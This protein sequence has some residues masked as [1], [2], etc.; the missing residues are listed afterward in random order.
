MFRVTFTS[1]REGYEQKDFA[2][3]LWAKSIAHI[4]AKLINHGEMC[5]HNDKLTITIEWV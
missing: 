4:V 2:D 1:D 5:G 3:K